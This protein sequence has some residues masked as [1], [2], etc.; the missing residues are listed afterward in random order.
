MDYE[1]MAKKYGGSSTGSSKPV[2]YSSLASKFG[3]SSAQAPVQAQ[4]TPG[5]YSRM[6][7]TM[8]DFSTG[9]TKGFLSTARNVAQ[10]TQVLGQKTLAALTPQSYDE[11][12]KMTGLKSLKDETVEGAGVKETLTPQEGAEKVGYGTEKVAEFFVPGGAVRSTEAKFAKMLSDSTKLKPLARGLINTAV[13]SSL[14]GVSAAGVTAAQGGDAEDISRAGWMSAAIAAPFKAFQYVKDPITGALK[15]SAAKEMS[16]ALGGQTTKAN[17]EL[18]EKTVPELLKRKYIVGFR[19]SAAKK[20][21]GEA[22]TIGEEIGAAW[23]NLPPETKLSITPMVKE[24]ED[25]KSGLTI[26][27]TDIIPEVAADKI[28]KLSAVQRELIDVA[29]GPGDDVVNKIVRGHLQSADDVVR[30][31][32]DEVA[33]APKEFLASVKRNIVDGLR[34]DGF[35]SQADYLDDVIDAGSFKNIDEMKQAIS[36]TIDTTGK[37]SSESL[38]SWRQIIDK[39]TKEKGKAMFGLTGDETT[40]MYAQKA[41]ANSMRNELAQNYPDIAKLNKEYTFWKNVESLFESASQRSTGQQTGLF[42]KGATIV[43]FAKAGPAGAAVMKYIT[44]ATQSGLWKSVSAVMKNE[45]AKAL[46]SG[47]TEKALEII[48]RS[49]IGATFKED[50]NKE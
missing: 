10:G 42:E 5:L 8:G 50:I 19:S 24:I 35:K 11:V 18:A 17:K 29:K 14:E 33:K 36:E 6:S 1:E 20:A 48:E 26:K 34:G 44:K 40:K 28:A 30:E 16:Q 23:E 3:G 12:R 2:D 13:G 32:P 31:I 7:S 47:K 38:R 43:G 46:A 4:S 22:D 41:L 37:I 15:Q 25:L 39:V 45:I 9:F 27:G 49:I 21:A